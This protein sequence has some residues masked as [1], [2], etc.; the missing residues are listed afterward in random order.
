MFKNK[1]KNKLKNTIALK[2][3]LYAI[4]LSVIFIVA[5][6]GLTIISTVFAERYPHFRGTF[7]R[8]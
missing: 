4:I 5:V 8:G 7:G 3:S 2:R 6:V 1:N